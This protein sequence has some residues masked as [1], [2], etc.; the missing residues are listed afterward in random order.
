MKENSALILVYA[1]L[2][3]NRNMMNKTNVSVSILRKDVFKTKNQS[4][5]QKKEQDI[6]DSLLILSNCITDNKD[7]IVSDGHI[8]IQSYEDYFDCGE[9]AYES[10][11]ESIKQMRDNLKSNCKNFTQNQLSIIAIEGN[12][13]FV[14]LTLKEYLALMSFVYKDTKGKNYK[15]AELL[16]LYLLI[17]SNISKNISLKNK[18]GLS[19]NKDCMYLDKIAKNS[20]LSQV[21]LKKYLDALC[22]CNMI[23]KYKD[24]VKVY[25]ILNPNFNKTSTEKEENK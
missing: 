16:N 21:T 4:I 9:I 8:Q 12:S 1:Y 17:K 3:I 15:I 22:Y 7:K 25:Y 10:L 5:I 20:K 14:K 6:I 24:E 18:F 2:I 19:Y 23:K 13:S 11:N